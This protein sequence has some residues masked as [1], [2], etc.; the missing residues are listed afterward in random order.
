MPKNNNTLILIATGGLLAAGAAAFFLLPKEAKAKEIEGGREYTFTGPA[1]IKMTLQAGTLDEYATLVNKF[2]RFG[3]EIRNVEEDWKELRV[4]VT[5]LWD[6]RGAK[7][8]TSGGP[9]SEKDPGVVVVDMEVLRQ[10]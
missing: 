1:V 7:T 5:W 2:K 4:S 9:F 8:W 10:L 3:S 6:D